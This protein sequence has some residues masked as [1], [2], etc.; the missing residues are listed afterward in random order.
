VVVVMVVVRLL[1]S[2]GEVSDRARSA[3]SDP[4]VLC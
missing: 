4:L 1:S 2:N 3:H